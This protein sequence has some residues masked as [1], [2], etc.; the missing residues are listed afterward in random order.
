M[1]AVF[2]LL[3][4]LNRNAIETYSKKTNIKTPNFKRFQEKCLIFD[5][6]YVGSLPCIPAR[7]DLHTGRINFLHRSWG[8]LEPFDESFPEI[9][10][11]NGVYSHIITDH[12]HYFADGG[13]TYHQRYSSWELVR[14]QAIDRWKGEVQP[15]MDFFKE[16]YHNVQHHRKNYMI[17]RE[18][19]TKE[20]EYC[21][22][23]VFALAEQF[24]SKNKDI[25]L[26][27]IH[28]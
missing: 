27:L 2:V 24:L 12:H 14:G 4:S 26:S 13:A 28:I 21:T 19:M 1:R 22:P 16:K 8:P 7:R 6:H 5:N 9:M 15:D 11:N 23:Q 10:K 20:E 3:D 25:D 18:Y 17:N